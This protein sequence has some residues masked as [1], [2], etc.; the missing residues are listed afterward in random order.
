MGIISKSSRVIAVSID[1]QAG[2]L[3]SVLEVVSAAGVSVEYMYAFLGRTHG[4][5]LM[6]IK[7]DDEAK[8]EAALK[9]AGTSVDIEGEI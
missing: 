2:G 9:V 5:A 6:V 4:K 1:D 8:A 7:T 3:A